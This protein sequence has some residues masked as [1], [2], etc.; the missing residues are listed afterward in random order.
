MHMNNKIAV[1][2]VLYQPDMAR[3]K[4]C[5]A[6]LEKQ[7]DKIYVFDNSEKGTNLND[8]HIVY[9]T[10]GKN[11]GIAYA[12]NKIMEKAQIDDFDWVVTMDQDSIVPDGMISGFR[13]CI[14]LH[15]D[16]GIICPQVID[17]RQSLF[18]S[19]KEQGRSLHRFLHHISFVHFY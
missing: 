9:M 11:R 6:N 8:E 2:I 12:L 10:E 4:Q 13:K 5:V 7:V 19:R 17:K 1:G 3:L 15:S 16:V 18:C 14:A